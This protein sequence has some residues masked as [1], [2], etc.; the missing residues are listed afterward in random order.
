MARPAGAMHACM[1]ARM[2]QRP[3][4]RPRLRLV[5]RAGASP[6]LS[7]H[8]PCPHTPL[9]HTPTLSH[10]M[11][12]ARQASRRVSANSF[13]LATTCACVARAWGYSTAR[14]AAAAG[15]AH[16]LSARGVCGCVAC[17]RACGCGCVDVLGSEP[18]IPSKASSM[19]VHAVMD[20]HISYH[21]TR[22]DTPF[23]CQ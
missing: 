10:V 1:R 18:G 3:Q 19:W 17:A 13:W 12:R 20:T 6:P 22:M 23:L 15:R 7:T 8:P 9:V 11:P 5:Q 2:P 21:V 16:A 14:P 4:R